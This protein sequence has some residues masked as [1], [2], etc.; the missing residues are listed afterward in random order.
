D[1]SRA[2]GVASKLLGGEKDDFVTDVQAEYHRIAEGHARARAGKSRL[3]YNAA[4]RNRLA[5]DWSGY[6]PP[7]PQFLGTKSFAEYDLGE[8]IDYIDWSPFFLTWEL[9]GRFPAILED[10]KVG[11]AA[12][13]LYDDAQAMLRRMVEEKWLSA[14]AVIGFWPAASVGD[15][16]VVFADENRNEE[17]TVLHTLRQ[18]MARNNDRPN[19]ALADFVAPR[20]SGLADYV[21]GFAVT[22]GIGE[23]ELAE[24][25]ARA[26]DDYSKILA[27]ALA[28]RLAEAFA[29]RM[30]E[31][32][33]REFWGYAADEE[34]S[35][36]DLIGER[37]RGIRPAHGYPA[38]PDHT[39]KATLFGLLDAPEA[40]G[41][42]LT[43]SFAML[44]A[45]SV[46]GLYFSHPQSAYF[47]VGRIERD[48]VE[49]YA[50]RKGWSIEEAERW[51]SPILNYERAVLDAAE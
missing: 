14:R 39:E 3:S 40:A 10:E 23:E 8:L 47:G 32:V 49:D 51:L 17:R 36:E 29:E 19:L 9:V 5:V 43:E 22:A 45:S 18:Q 27:Q 24:R 41:I 38:Q 26:N 11:V 7:R 25:F 16:I 4:R 2:V 48:Q 44:P 37:F 42:R 13:A 35:K 6:R 34:L 1:A 15:D 30:H 46:S 31:R 21:G 12:R 28:D 50:A 33:R 20:D